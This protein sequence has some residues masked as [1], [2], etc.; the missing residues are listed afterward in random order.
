MRN[1][2][3][4]RIN[5][6]LISWKFY[7]LLF[8]I[9][10]FIAIDEAIIVWFCKDYFES[11]IPLLLWWII[12]S[13]LILTTTIALI[14]K[15]IW[16][17]PILLLSEAA[18]QITAGD[19]SV[20]VPSTRKDGKKD[21]AE[22]LI[23]DFNT[24]VKELASTEILKNDFIANVS[25]EIKSPISVI[26]SYAQTLQ[27]ADLS[28]GEKAQCIDAIVSATKKL[29][30]MIV[31][32]LKLNK[33]E[34]Q[35]IT[36]CAAEYQLG[37]Q[38]RQCALGFM[39]LWEKK[40][41]DFEIDVC[42]VTVRHDPA[43]MELVWNN[44]LS[45]AVK[46]TDENGSIRLTSYRRDELIYVS[47]KDSGCGMDEKTRNRIFD[48]FYQGDT[49][50]STEGNGLGLAILKRVAEIENLNIDVVSEPGKGTEFIVA[51]NFGR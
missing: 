3:D 35:N 9:F 22:V 34:N 32:I 1:N 33:L 8:A 15:Y 23:D 46:F 29:N 47:V 4:T 14:R 48:K 10:V 51:L 37:E 39:E 36:S 45:N 30:E 17:K 12:S 41:I 38:L 18:K 16:N 6:P 27:S 49:S 28:E 25:H 20:R 2:N 50:H 42:D 40:N 11:L 19:Y 43:L 5:T 7:L 31:N 13:S 21:A 26:Q 44:L 24:M